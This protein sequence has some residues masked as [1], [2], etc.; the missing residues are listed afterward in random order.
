MRAFAESFTDEEK[1]KQLV[2]QL[3]WGHIVRLMQKVKVME[4]PRRTVTMPNKTIKDI[5]PPH[6]SPFEQIRRTN[7]AGNE[8]WSSRDFAR[9]LDYSDYR[10]FEQVIAKARTACFNSGQ[11]IDDHFVD[12]TEMVEVNTPGGVNYFHFGNNCRRRH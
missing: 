12:V 4:D 2:S 10:N 3:P 9:V 11:R 5:A 6:Q 1:V 7:D 8:Y